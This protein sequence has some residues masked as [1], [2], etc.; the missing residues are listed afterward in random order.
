MQSATNNPLVPTPSHRSRT[1]KRLLVVVVVIV[2]LGGLATQ[3]Q[4][5]YDWGR[6][7]NYTPSTTVATIAAD[8]TMTPAAR[9]V[10]YV[11][12]PAISDK[13][14]FA[15]Q[16]PSGTEQTVVLGCYHGDQS[17]VYVL[18]VGDVRL[19]GIEQVTSAHELLHAEYDRLSARERS[20][21]DGWLEDYYQHDLRD[22][23]TLQQIAEYK[24]SEPNAVTDEMH[25]LFGTQLG[26][27][28]P[29]LEQYYRRYF[30]DRAKIVS[31]Y[32]A[33]EGEFTS[34]QATIKADD[35]QLTNWKQQISNDES[36]LRQMSDDLQQRQ[37][38]LTQQRTTNPAAYNQAIPSYNA[39]IDSYDTLLSS[40][41][42]LI[43]QYNNLVMKRNAV[44]LE[45][46]QLTK[47]I[48]SQVSSFDN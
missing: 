39:A 29:Q 35:T 4:A 3:R 15:H 1:K 40:Y 48:N 30:A 12:H 20:Q 6:L 5:L 27:L 21:V 41:R 8:D 14:D 31:Y 45:T 43:D 46:Q 10:F 28:S 22:Q 16:C 19:N 24:K 42:S 9:R 47:E 11:N 2:L 25:S 7:E 17:G 32:S 13:T 38:Q 18:Q 36:N 34:R 23:T 37:Q 44:A 33:Y 26:S